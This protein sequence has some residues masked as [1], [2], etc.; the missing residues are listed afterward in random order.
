MSGF[1]DNFLW[2]GAT[3][4]NQ[5]EG[6][7]REGG[8]GPSSSDY[9]PKGKYRFQVM[10]GEMN[11]D[12]LPAGLVYPYRT[13]SDHYHHWKEDIGLLGEMGFKVYRM[14]ICWSRIYPTG[15][16]E[17]PNEEGL[18][19]YENIF[20]ECRRYGIEPLV[21]MCHY[22][23]PMALVRKY[24]G[25][26]SRETVDCFVKY[27]RTILERYKGLVKYW[28]TFNEINDIVYLPYITGGVIIDKAKDRNQQV[29]QAAHH[30]FLASSM[31]VKM[32]HEIDPENKVGCMVAAGQTYPYTCSPDDIW[33]AYTT[34][35]NTY[36]FTDVMVRGVYPRYKKL[37]FERNKVKIPFG[38]DDL[39]ILRENTVDFIS[40]SYY[41]SHLV[42]ANANILAEKGEG[43][44][45]PTLRNPYLKDKESAW[46]WQ[47][48]AEGLRTTLNAFYDRYRV[49]LFIAEN[50]V[51]GI[52]TVEDGKVHDQYHIHNIG[53]HILEMRKAVEEDGVDLIGYTSWAC[54]DLIS[55]STGEMKKRYGYVYVD[56][57]ENGNG[58]YKRIRKDS[59]YWYKDVIARNGEIS[60]E[61]I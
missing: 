11:P 26:E 46:K 1:P 30:L 15:M 56:A 38:K 31:A 55:A 40:F 10:S 3:A 43:N 36:F 4:A 53:S 54:I 45:F 18:R 33:L 50:G 29:W 61:D 8:R 14:S 17:K 60:E 39:Q 20:K 58:S 16:E 59:F 21:T 7:W 35:R 28:L 24:N 9:L 25:F 34:D 32:A 22:D 12:D 49:P 19:F 41:C 51:G 42:C 23:I 48:D 27:A 52:D 2:G 37:E 5:F 57:N 6:G 13:A 47:L 44:V